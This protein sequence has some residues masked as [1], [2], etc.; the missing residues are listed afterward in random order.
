[1]S[2][3]TTLPIHAVWESVIPAEDRQ[4]Y[5]EAGFGTTRELGS[6]PC[7]LVIDVVGAFLGPRPGDQATDDDFMACGA[8]GWQRLP[9][10]VSLV[11]EARGAGVPVVFV[12][13][14]LMA[15][16]FCGGSVKATADPATSARIHTAGFPDELQ[17]R[18]D[19]FVLEK[20]RPSAFFGTPLS[21]YLTR[22]GIDT[23]VVA[24]TTTSGCVR[25]TVVDAASHNYQVAVLEEG[26]FDRSYFSHVVNMFEMQQKYAD[27]V[28]LARLRTYFTSLST[29]PR[30]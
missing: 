5:A 9:S 15:K 21:I 30:S 27:V 19:E 17:P 28:D 7:V 1:M 12:K 18:D 6:R 26:C 16:R 13:G 8:M 23:L 3:N 2:Q 10:I 25:A 4:L 11:D 14:S 24:G 20:S 29:S 22:L